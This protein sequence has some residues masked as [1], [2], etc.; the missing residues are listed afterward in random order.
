MSARPVFRNLDLIFAQV[1]QY[2]RAATS[3]AIPWLEKTLTDPR[4]EALVLAEADR[5][6]VLTKN[7]GSSDL[8]CEVFPSRLDQLAD[9]AAE[10]VRML[11]VRRDLR[12]SL[13]ESEVYLLRLLLPKGA[14]RNPRE[15]IKYRL[16]T[17]SPLRLDEVLFDACVV[18]AGT[19]AGGSIA[20]VAV[21]RRQSLDAL[22]AGATKIGL[23]GFHLGLTRRCDVDLEFTF[24]RAAGV[25]T[26]STRLQ[27]NCLLAL[28]PFAIAFL[29]LTAS[30]SYASWKS[31]MLQKEILALSQSKVGASRLLTRRS[32]LASAAAAINAE[33]PSVAIVELLN[34]LGRGLPQTAWLSELRLE[35]GKLRLIGYAADPPAV[36]AALS[37]TAG[38]SA[39]RLETVT[40]DAAA[41]QQSHFEISA[42][43]VAKGRN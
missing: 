38:L 9:A 37:R 11:C 14:A 32:Q 25:Q 19:S 17:E 13:V 40:S 16:L 1:K 21:C 39:V 6:I 36:A 7:I 27:R 34:T 35:S 8:Q 20:E 24:E 43:I 22:R 33:R 41:A 42:E 4:A 29:A 23:A 5:T 30:W 10:R 3:S 15:A 26:A 2:V 31:G 12:L 18:S 28:A